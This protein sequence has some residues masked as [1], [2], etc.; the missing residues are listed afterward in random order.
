MEHLDLILKE[1]RGSVE[2]AQVGQTVQAKKRHQVHPFQVGGSVL[3]DT[4]DL[5]EAY[6]SSS[7][8]PT[9]AREGGP[10]TVLTYCSN[11]AWAGGDGGVEA[12]QLF[13]FACFRGVVVF[14]LFFCQ[15]DIR[16]RRKVAPV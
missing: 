16:G 2:A 15:A 13:C 3:L 8:E 1:L 9:R 7:T 4:R 11:A 6:A 5:T 14:F 10:F 12:R